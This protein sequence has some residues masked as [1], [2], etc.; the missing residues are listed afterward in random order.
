[1]RFL[2]NANAAYEESDEAVPLQL[3]TALE[4]LEHLMT[5]GQRQAGRHNLVN[6]NELGGVPQT[7]G[8][9]AY[10]AMVAKLADKLEVYFE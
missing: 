6:G 2:R 7:E 8:D 10:T 5:Y 4:E 9:K 3:D 1:M